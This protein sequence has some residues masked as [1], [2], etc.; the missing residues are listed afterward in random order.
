[1]SDDEIKERKDLLVELW[2][3]GNLHESLLCQKSR[4]KW[5]QE[6][7]ENTSFF[8]GVINWKRRSNNL[9]GLSL[10][11]RWEEDPRVV[12]LEVKEFF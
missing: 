7:D 12:K 3:V 9:K 1:M 6:G 4:V 11:G 2:H 10:N 5:L 8:H